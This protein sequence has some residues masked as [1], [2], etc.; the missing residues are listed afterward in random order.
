MYT[1]QILPALM[2]PTMALSLP[3]SPIDTPTRSTRSYD[4]G[5]PACEVYD[6]PST[7]TNPPKCW[8]WFAATTPSNYC[9][10]S[11]FVP[12]PASAAHVKANS[13]DWLESCGTLREEILSKPGDYYLADYATDRF[14]TLVTSSSPPSPGT[15]CA[16]Q[17]Q[18]ATPP[19]SEEIYVGGTDITDILGSAIAASQERARSDGMEGIM[20]CGGDA[21]R[22]RMVPF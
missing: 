10:D 16:L 6:F 9:G 18:P 22:W 7:P 19:S 11:T 20:P 4:V 14:N 3:S 1:R 21:V 15:G 17:V 2:L 13:P 12:V 8:A 5:S